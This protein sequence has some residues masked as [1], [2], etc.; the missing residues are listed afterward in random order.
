MAARVLMLALVASAGAFK[1]QDAA[2]AQIGPMR[3]V[4]TL[5]ED[6]KKQVIADGEDDTAS[7]EKYS[8]WCRTSENQKNNAIAE[9]DQNIA[10]LQ[11]FLEEAAGTEAQLKTE[12]EGLIADIKEDKD[13]LAT[14]TGVRNEDNAAFAATEADYKETLAALKDA[15]AVLSKVQLLQKNGASASA[16][17]VQAAHT[18]LLQ[19]KR[20]VQQKF[21]KFNEV[22]ERDLFDVLGSFKVDHKDQ[23][24]NKKMM[25]A[26][27]IGEVFLPKRQAAALEQSK[28]GALGNPNYWEPSEE[29]AGKAKKKNDLSGAAAGAKSYNSRSGQIFGVLRAMNDQFL[30]DLGN[31]QK[32]EFNSLVEFEHLRAAKLGE[33]AEAENQQSKKETELADLLNKV[34]NAEKDLDKTQFA[35]SED[36][37]FLEHMKEG[38]A[39]EANEFE[40][41]TTIRNEEI[42]ALGETLAIL[43]DDSARELMGK[44]LSFLQVDASS[45]AEKAAIQDRLSE[46]AMKRLAAVAKKHHNML[47]ASLAVRVRLD[48]FTEVKQMMDKMHGDLSKQQQDEYDKNERCKKELD[49][50]EDDIKVGNEEKDDLDEKHLQL[51]NQL[52]VLNDE[53]AQLQADGAAN[54][55]S[56]KQAGEARK[57]ENLAFSQTVSDQRATI[58]ILQKALKRLQEF[59][60]PKQ[61]LVQVRHDPRAG[62]ADEPDKPKAYGKSESSGGA[63]QMLMK[64]INDAEAAEAEAV[65]S[66]QHDQE[67]YA[68][69]VQDTTNSIEADRA[70]VE[71]KQEE[72]AKLMGLKAETEEAQLAESQS[73]MKLGQLLAATHMDCDWMMKNFETTQ[74]ARKEEMDAIED[75]KAI[76]SGANY[77]R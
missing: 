46:R 14:A 61:A 69:L 15:V 58:N 77:P 39:T 73:L 38:C 5:L 63:L 3:K 53:I 62:L 27:L 26:A 7:Y 13:T 51:T 37:E 28:A 10:D 17:E 67:N 32:E 34:A 72:V 1:L 68:T 2:Q 75:A 24:I 44:T 43:T 8:C 29:E 18:A 60:T 54:E 48:A 45:L 30:R 76:L 52:Q 71:Q 50:T 11:A 42:K 12:I 57:A 65:V 59:Y 21:P 47:L 74:K 33:I 22:M 31:A 55:V 64:V 4:V 36:M 16:K 9:A 20:T 41:R 6:M 66:E 25:S 23:H 19:V 40:K 56:L 70:S 35:R 49:Q